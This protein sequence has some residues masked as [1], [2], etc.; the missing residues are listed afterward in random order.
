MPWL[1]IAASPQM[2]GCCSKRVTP[3]RPVSVCLLAN[4]TQ[5]RQLQLPQRLL[6]RDDSADV[7]SV[8]IDQQCIYPS[9]PFASFAFCIVPIILFSPSPS[10]S[11]LNLLFCRQHTTSRD[12]SGEVRVGTQLPSQLAFAILTARLVAVSISLVS[13]PRSTGV[14]ADCMPPPKFFLDSVASFG[15]AFGFGF[16][17]GRSSSLPPQQPIFEFELGAFVCDR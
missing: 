1:T 17:S 2:N 10:L 15:S 14:A 16:H 6:R 12:S 9:Q 8:C 11:C 13:G 4:T 7:A 5:V 3:A